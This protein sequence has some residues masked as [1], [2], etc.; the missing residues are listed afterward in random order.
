MS[1][2]LKQKKSISNE[3]KPKNFEEINNM[4]A[5]QIKTMRPSFSTDIDDRTRKN[6]AKASARDCLC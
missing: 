3:F 1:L 4:D 5:F 6:S 2:D